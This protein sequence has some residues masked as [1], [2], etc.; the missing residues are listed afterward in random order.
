MAVITIPA[1]MAA[2]LQAQD[3][4][5]LHADMDHVSGGNGSAFT[6]LLGPPRWTTTLRSKRPLG[7][8]HAGAWEATALRLRGRINHLAVHDHLRP[9]P[10]GTA[11]GSGIT[12]TAGVAVGAT[13]VAITGALAGYNLLANPSFEADTDV[14]GLA[15]NWTSF[16]S[17]TV[18]TVGHSRLDATPYGLHGSWLQQTTATN[19]QT[20]QVSRIGVRQ[21]VFTAPQLA[22]QPYS[23]AIKAVADPPGCLLRLLV[24][25]HTAPFQWA[26]DEFEWIMSGTYTRYVAGGVV[27]TDTTNEFRVTAYICQRPGSAGAAFLNV[28]EAQLELQATPAD[29]ATS[30]G[31]ATL[32][33]G[34]WLQIGSGVGSHLARVAAD[35]TLDGSGAGTVTFEPPARAA[36]SSGA[37]VTV[38]RALGHYRLLQDAV[39]FDAQS[40]GPHTAG[41]D[42]QLV[43]S[44]A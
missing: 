41:M 10:R 37:A 11:R 2:S 12:T 16:S 5:V 15:D 34:D 29:F 28:D 1:D 30:G 40:N 4:G 24:S 14:D 36:F 7:V 33:R 21:I 8:Q 20:S 18:G 23:V 9:L 26:V 43:E 17:G 42:L 6:Q 38:E 25:Q 3:F 39:T 19:L 27:N 31:D 44:W 32:L 13:S 35:V 22:G